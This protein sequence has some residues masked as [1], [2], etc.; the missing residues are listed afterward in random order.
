MPEGSDDGDE[1]VT[2]RDRI[3]AALATLGSDEAEVLALVSERL[4]MG[5]RQYGELRPATDP[6]DF[7]REALRAR[8]L[9]RR[10]TGS[11]TSPQHS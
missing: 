9:R 4:A 10:R 7:A 5:R 2:P 11:C 8:R 1:A 3:L 6:R